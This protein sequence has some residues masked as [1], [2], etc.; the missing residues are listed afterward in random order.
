M[1]SEVEDEIC[2]DEKV[3]EKKKPKKVIS[4][5]DR[6]NF[7]NFFNMKLKER[8]E[9]EEKEKSKRVKSKEEEK[10][11]KEKRIAEEKLKDVFKLIW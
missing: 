10:K 1:P 6:H 8:K 11:E 4:T 9:L 7:F 5:K 3:Q 2:H